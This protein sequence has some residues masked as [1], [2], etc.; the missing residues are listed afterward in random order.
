MPVLEAFPDE[1]ALLTYKLEHGNRTR[2]RSA[3]VYFDRAEEII[4]PGTTVTIDPKQANARNNKYI[5]KIENGQLASFIN[6]PRKVTALSRRSYPS[7]TIESIQAGAPNGLERVEVKGI[8]KQDTRTVKLTAYTLDY[9][10]FATIKLVIV[11]KEDPKYN[12]YFTT[13]ER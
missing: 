6:T 13:G 10:S 2:S 8:H 7:N 5:Y 9:Q 3:V 4:L 12:S 1:D 11:G